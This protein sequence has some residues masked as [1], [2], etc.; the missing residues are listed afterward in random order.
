MSAKPHVIVW[1]QK[2]INKQFEQERERK[3]SHGGSS[4]N[5]GGLGNGGGSADMHDD[6]ESPH[7]SFAG[8][9]MSSDNFQDTDALGHDGTIKSEVLKNC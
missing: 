2:L 1:K 4:T 8:L 7:S 3:E 9:G 6:P 5:S